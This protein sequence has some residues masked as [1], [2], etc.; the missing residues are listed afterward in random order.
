MAEPRIRVALVD[1]YVLVRKGMAMMLAAAGDIEVVG[2]ASDGDEVLDL[3]DRTSP[4]VVLMDLRMPRV[5]GVEATRRLHERHPN[6]AV[7]VMT[8]YAD[9]ARLAEAAEAGASGSLV[10]DVEEDAL[11]EAVRR[12]A[13]RSGAS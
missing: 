9:D 10:K 8:A 7:I 3:V 11:C 13:G 5:D 1:D 6:A 12:A 4:D 2:E